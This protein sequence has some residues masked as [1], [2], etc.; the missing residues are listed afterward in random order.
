MKK[1]LTTHAT[2]LLLALL[3]IVTGFTQVDATTVKL[4]GGA[5]GGDWN[6]SNGYT[7]TEST[8]TS[9]LYYYTVSLNGG[10]DIYIGIAVDGVQYGKNDQW[11]ERDTWY[12]LSKNNGNAPK[13]WFGSG[14]SGE[15]TFFFNTNTNEF[16][17]QKGSYTETVQADPTVAIA[18]DFNS[19]S[20]S[21]N[22]LTKTADGVY[23]GTITV[24][25]PGYFKFVY[26]DGNGGS[27][28]WT[29]ATAG[30]KVTTTNNSNISF[31]TYGSGDNIAL[32]G[33]GTLTF[34]VNLNTKKFSVSGLTA[35]TE[36][37]YNVYVRNTGSNT[38]PSLYAFDG[39]FISDG[40][41]TWAGVQ[42]TTT[43]TVNGY[44]WYK[45]T[46]TS[47]SN[48]L[49]VLANVNGDDHKTS[50]ITVSA[51]DYYI[52]FDATASSDIT[53]SYSNSTP[54]AAPT[55][56]T[57]NVYVLNYGS[58]TKPYLYAF[59][60]NNI[61][62][63]FN[64][65]PGVQGSSTN[66]V[67]LNGET[68][69]R[70][71]FTSTSNSLKIIANMGS[72]ANQ[73]A[74]NLTINTGDY[75][76]AFDG[77]VSSNAIPT[78]YSS[79][80]V[81]Q[82]AVTPKTTVVMLGGNGDWNNGTPMTTSDNNVFTLSNV[83]FS[84]TKSFRFKETVI[85]GK[86]LAPTS[87]GFRVI[88]GTAMP[89][90]EY[91]G[92]TMN[93]YVLPA[94]TY[95]FTV[96]YSNKTVTVTGTPA[97][98]YLLT[99]PA[100]GNWAFNTDKA[101]SKNGNIYTISNL[102]LNQ[103]DLFVLATIVGGDWNSST[104]LSGGHD[105][106]TVASGTATDCIESA[107]GCY[108]IPSTGVWSIS[109]N[110]SS[111]KMTA[112]K[113]GETTKSATI[114]V[115]D[116]NSTVTIGFNGNNVATTSEAGNY[117][118]WQKATVSGAVATLNATIQ[119]SKTLNVTLNDGDVKYYYL[120]GNTYTETNV[121]INYNPNASAGFT[122]YVIDKNNAVTPY[123]H[124][125]YNNGTSDINIL[126]TNDPKWPGLQLSETWL[127]TATNETWYK[128]T[129]TGYSKV[130]VIVN[131]GGN[132]H[133]T[134]NITDVN[135]DTYIV[136]DSNKGTDSNNNW[137]APDYRGN[138]VPS[139]FQQPVASF[140]LVHSDTSGN[141][142]N[143]ST[144]NAMTT[145]NKV[146]YTL[147]VTLFKDSYFVFTGAVG[148]WNAV[149]GDRYGPS[150]SSDVTITSGTQY[151]AA[152]GNG[153]SKA[154]KI[155]AS[156]TWHFTYNVIDNKWT[157]T[158]T[159]PIT[160]YTY[161]VYVRNTA[162]NNNVA[163]TLYA[164]GGA[165][166]TPNGINTWNDNQ[167]GVSG[168]AV[169]NINA[170]GKT[171]YHFT[172]TSTT[173]TLSVI[174]V[175]GSGHQTSDIALVPGDHYI[176]FNGDS[177]G[178]Q[179]NPITPSYDATTAPEAKLYLAASIASIDE[180]EWKQTE[181]AL[182]DGSYSITKNSVN[183]GDEFQFVFKDG[184]DE[185]WYGGISSDYYG[186][187]P[188][189]C[190][191]IAL[192]DGTGGNN[193]ANFRVIDGYGNLTFTVPENLAT[194][195]ITG[196]T[197]T[198]NQFTIYV[199]SSWAPY[200]HVF[201]TRV[202]NDY[203]LNE[204]FNE[205][206][207]VL[208]TTETLVD[209]KSWYKLQVTAPTPTIKVI[210]ADGTQSDGSN[211]QTVTITQSNLTEYYIYNYVDD[212][213][214]QANVG[215]KD[216]RLGVIPL[217]GKDLYLIG[218]ANGHGW[219]P[220]N[221]LK[222]ERN[223]HVYTIENVQLTKA[224]DQD[225]F[226]FASVLAETND[227]EN[228]ENVVNP[229]RLMSHLEHGDAIDE[230]A[231]G[232]KQSIER[233]HADHR[234]WRMDL[235]GRF[236]ITVDLDNEYIMVERAHEALYMMGT[237]H[238]GGKD[239]TFR[240]SDAAEMQTSDGKIYT[241]SGVTL[242]YTVDGNDVKHGNTFQFIKELTTDDAAE[243]Y[244]Y[245][246][247]N[248]LRMGADGA[249]K[250]ITDDDINVALPAATFDDNTDY[251][252]FE[253]NTRGKFMVI[254][255]LTDAANPT[256]T[257]RPMASG[258]NEMTVH[259]EKT[260]NVA[261]PTIVAWDKLKTD[262]SNNDFATSDGNFNH[263]NK[264]S[265]RSE[266]TTADGRQW[267]TW[268]IQ[269]A[270]ADFYFT[271]TNGSV[272]QSETLWR[273]AGNVYYT[274]PKLNDD[275]TEDETRE[276]TSV[277][278][279]GVPDCAQMLE[280]HYYAY[281]INTPGWKQVFCHAWNGSGDMLPKSDDPNYEHHNQYPG[282][283]CELVGY[284]SEGYEVWRFDFTEYFGG[285]GNFVEPT[286]II[287][288]NGVDDKDNGINKD[289]STNPPT[290]TDENKEQSGD[291]AY[292]NGAVFDYLGMLVT[293]NSLGNLIVKGI[294]EGPEYSIDSNLEVVYFDRDAEETIGEHHIYGALY[295]KDSDEF[296]ST[297]LVEKSQIQSG[298]IDY[299][300]TKT[301]LMDGHSR[302][303]QSNWIKLTLST[304]YFTDHNNGVEM[305]KTQQLELL[306]QYE[307]KILPAGEV[308]GQLMNNVNPAFHVLDLP[309]VNDCKPGSYAT[310][311]NVMIPANFVGTQN[312]K[313][314]DYE[315]EG[316][317]RYFFVTPKPYEFV[318][319]TWAV[320]ENDA[321]Y[322]PSRVYMNTGDYPQYFNEGDLDG[323]FKVEWDMLEQS[324]TP[325]NGEVYQFDAIVT[326]DETKVSMP[327]NAPSRNTSHKGAAANKYEYI[328]KPLNISGTGAIITA[329]KDV[330]TAKT[331]K[332]VRYY[333]VAGVESD[334]PFD[335]VNIIVTEYND[336]TVTTSKQLR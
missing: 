67:S 192:T 55:V 252:D 110:A 196:W 135:C 92:S 93:S 78:I 292:D 187:H 177:E 183:T 257:L 85:T 254:V 207:A 227:I 332:A 22:M 248:K 32:Y 285:N 190:S 250:K 297:P 139:G 125:W 198:S 326:L 261:N 313:E 146:D 199:R 323:Y 35:P 84:E 226:A 144:G 77:T 282:V 86:E 109:Y 299:M 111:L 124:A 113:T 8:V 202:G 147:D 38:A 42:G 331:V 182:S 12:T 137:Q 160:V 303:D 327:H 150:G 30:T 100:S 90:T 290:E 19:W 242:D 82:S 72:N 208:T 23:S 131:D 27:D 241:L 238:Y 266:I 66:T 264:V 310:A 123:L 33:T 209:G 263:V 15:Q 94:G 217:I 193:R 213:N 219:A 89:L 65:W 232:Q 306:G 154:Y 334:K 245:L 158:L 178:T 17:Y 300:M 2:R 62:G 31:S 13:I 153:D 239:Y 9:G 69:Y 49:K 161:N 4:Y 168:T 293:G 37:T 174:A 203:V 118:T 294:I 274:W 247:T 97:A 83:E 287:F 243:A 48:S 29:G 272:T 231:L 197:E 315:H 228:W 281:F 280:D 179:A 58:S 121:G 127:N 296:Y 87:E 167:I 106:Q 20:T 34:T 185:V 255:N 312:C 112:T 43:A 105:D 201:Y 57:Y 7:M 284:D 81:P 61:S 108:K 10:S 107:S 114:Y 41:D 24:S 278:A 225:G 151:S 295:C 173:E 54:P 311:P 249:V 336:G 318:H 115:Y 253:M 142:W 170:L 99:H 159:T 98:V 200:A 258:S 91:S 236:N 28:Q 96:N 276:Y 79:A 6:I 194:V 271:R 14:D 320:Y 321:F 53:P 230:A 215:N 64:T 205:G 45:F 256:V 291:F 141:D 152:E 335:G 240:P 59:N 74:D 44:T 117:V 216:Y 60:G 21:A 181:M 314:E 277:S 220:N 246:Q 11:C 116:P 68:W 211:N 304:R 156:G 316:K 51:G 26:N 148:D 237:Y 222:M 279:P 164:F 56:Y 286:G 138:S 136:W 95:T 328:V 288:N 283:V 1:L 269:N 129:F 180:G 36:Y 71:T 130:S 149:N 302:Y 325:V 16:K 322:V 265:E 186:V 224:S 210:F 122:V 166:Y 319:I 133:Q 3:C 47:T 214:T 195:T 234:N 126:P 270:I 120:D 324:A 259:L 275:D 101:L 268:T 119:G 5:N 155:P 103:N 329:V 76:I 191:N 218:K 18:G 260:D 171:W 132:G 102:T 25:S 273:R 317:N 309:N 298:E 233:Y 333:N 307:N 212:N 145:T 188:D 165:N 235:T 163:P 244:A 39:E 73:T 176:A 175:A 104:L 308:K 134:A 189:H 206:K 223:G 221:G 46:F 204:G 289:Y 162:T 262:P 305:T 169:T 88:R 70:F 140:Y 229:F 143:V 184:V 80:T 157:G 251:Y 40:Y 128:Y 75:Y 301:H 50:N 172:V 63:D 330:E 267:Y 52:V